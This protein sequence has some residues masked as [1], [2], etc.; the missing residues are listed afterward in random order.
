MSVDQL[1]ERVGKCE[2]PCGTDV[3]ICLNGEEYI[4]ARKVYFAEDD[5]GDRVLVVDNREEAL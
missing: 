2:D 1:L 4:P 3:M 5:R